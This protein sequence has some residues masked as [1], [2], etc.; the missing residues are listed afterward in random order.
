MMFKIYFDNELVA[1]FDTL[2]E[3][4]FN[5]YKWDQRGYNPHI[6]KDGMRIL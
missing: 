4:M 2:K 6:E 3:A 1:S 5:Y